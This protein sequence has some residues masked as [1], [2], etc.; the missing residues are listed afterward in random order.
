MRSFDGK[1][2]FTREQYDFHGE[3]VMLSFERRKH[4]ILKKVNGKIRRNRFMM[5][6]RDGVVRECIK[7]WNALQPSFD[8]LV[9]K[10]KLDFGILDARKC[11]CLLLFFVVFLVRIRHLF[12]F[13]FLF[14]FF[15]NIDD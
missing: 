2:R 9:L 11:I 6:L 4:G 10:L 13:E 5:N 12:V 1:T 14:V 15:F 3:C 8:S 7:I